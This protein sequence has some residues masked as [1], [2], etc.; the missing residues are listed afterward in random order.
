[1]RSRL[2]TYV[3][4]GV[5]CSPAFGQAPP[6]PLQ[7]DSSELSE[8][9]SYGAEVALRSGHADRGFIINDRPVVQ[10]VAWLSWA[11]VSFSAWSS[12]ALATTTDGA[13]PR[14][15]ELELSRGLEWGDLSIEPAG[16]LYFYHDPLSPYST[17]SLEGWLYVSYPLGPVSLF[18]NQ[19]L[20][21]LTYR[22]GY[23]G[24]VG[25]ES[26]REMSGGWEAGGSVGAGWASSTFNDEWVGVD[27]WAMNRIAVEAWLTAH[28][29]P[30]FYVGPYFEL[31]AILDRRVRAEQSTFVL[32]GLATGIEF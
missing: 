1:M 13:R 30:G 14:I 15:V 18:S 23:F 26:E 31:D 8:P 5:W 24:E 9:F 29:Q 3:A 28:V 19:S 7:V 4:L 2:A 11:G 20:D 17:H 21:L 32:V 6:Y 12:F 10:P 16:R 22:G 25:I 27:R